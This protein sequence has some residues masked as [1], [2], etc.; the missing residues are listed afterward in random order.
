MNSPLPALTQCDLRKIRRRPKK[1]EDKMKRRGEIRGG[2]D[3]KHSKE[4]N[5]YYRKNAKKRKASCEK[6]EE[7][8]QDITQRREEKARGPLTNQR[9]LKFRP[10]FGP[11]CKR[12]AYKSKV[13][14]KDQE[15]DGEHTKRD[16]K[17]SKESEQIQQD[18]AYQR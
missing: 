1:R 2:L 14:K 17:Q 5:E 7:I 9:M 12:R 10:K 6:K 4:I 16:R 11:I 8:K 3:K 15:Q 13:M 18:R